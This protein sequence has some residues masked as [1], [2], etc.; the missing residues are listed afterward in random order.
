[1]LS[2]IGVNLFLIFVC[3]LL[4]FMLLHHR[5]NPHT[6]TLTHFLQTLET[7]NLFQTLDKS[8][9]STEKRALIWKLKWKRTK[10]SMISTLKWHNE[11]KRVGGYPRIRPHTNRII[12]LHEE[13]SNNSNEKTTRRQCV[14][15]VWRTACMYVYM[16]E[17]IEHNAMRVQTCHLSIGRPF[18]SRD[19]HEQKPKHIMFN[20]FHNFRVT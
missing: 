17:P 2:L 19:A 3:V 9:C 5:C 4:P 8:M 7:H 13:K 12:I 18:G 20:D 10:R 11:T 16:W 6:F 15:H 14:T 1:M